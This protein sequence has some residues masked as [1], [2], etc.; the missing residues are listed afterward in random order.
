[1]SRLLLSLALL[2]GSLLSVSAQ[3][4]SPETLDYKINYKWGLIHKQAGTA[5][6]VLS[7]PNVSTFDARLYARTQPWADVLYKVRDTLT[8]TFS[9]S[10]FMPEVYHRIAHE[11][12][13]YAHDILKFSRSGNTSSAVCRRIRR[14]K[15][16]TSNTETS[17]SLSA[18]GP[19]V[20]LLSSFYYIRTLPYSTL[21]PGYKQIVNI[22]SG[23]RK[24][25]L[26]ITY[27]GKEDLKMDK[28]TQPVYHI[29]FTFTSEGKKE[30]SR[31]I[32][33]WLST[34]PGHVP[35]KL[36][37]ELKIGKVQCFLIQ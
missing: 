24:E 23:K 11:D 31:P 35:L 3:S 16:D 15:K 2:L 28:I 36:V 25:L 10:T 1:M 7:R 6:F 19:T 27:L 14:G 20:D 13:S 37:G 22:F 32:D 21:K 9:S 29:R 33:A 4:L 12:G 30:T 26:A 8:T 18:T 5:R 17:I 34:S